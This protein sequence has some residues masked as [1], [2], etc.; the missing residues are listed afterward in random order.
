MPPAVPLGEITQLLGAL[1]RGDS[2][3]PSWLASLVYGELRARARRYLRRDRP[4][5]AL[6]ATALG[7]S[8]RGS[9]RVWLQAELNRPDS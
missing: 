2:D 4:G 6:Q 1:K 9:A 3:A 8:S 5:H 7:L